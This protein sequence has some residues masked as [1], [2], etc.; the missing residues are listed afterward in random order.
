M[1]DPL[2]IHVVE[3]ARERAAFVDLP[4]RI[5]AGLPC[6]VP[7]LRRMLRH[8]LDFRANPF[9]QHAEGCLFIARRGTAVLGRICA[10]IDHAYIAQWHEPVGSFG[11]F[12][13]VD[14]V[15]VARALV[16]AAAA[17][18][19]QR[20]MGVLRGPMSPS[21]HGEWGLL[22]EGFA[23]PPALLMPYN[24][25]YYRALLE[26]CG[27]RPAKTVLAYEKTQD[28]QSPAALARIAARL[29][30]NPRVR[31]ERMRKA[32]LQ[33][34][35]ETVRALYN[36]TWSEQWGFAPLSTAEMHE[37]LDA[38]R[39]FGREELALLA[40]YDDQPVG[41]CITLPDIN[42]ILRDA[43]G[44]LGVRTLWRLLF[45]QRRITGCRT[46]LLGFLP[47]F[48]R[49]GL[50]ALLYHASETY[51]RAHFQRIEFSWILEDNLPMQTLISAIGATVSKR[52]QLFELQLP[53]SP[54]P[55]SCDEHC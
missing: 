30:R 28:S 55:P 38:V 14:E 45:Q 2:H 12:E 5:Y 7:P 6:W 37:F 49:T 31:I 11:F 32:A 10:Q 16:H 47:Q 48:R 24:P 46:M 15:V 42:E 23:R 53:A 9:W 27:L 19:Q 40:Y 50:P 34:K 36:V 35:A 17:W 21:C 26:A 8:Q 51:V 18:L 33:R 44:R 25:P 1:A 3:S 54:S 43:N 41:L 52:Y 22:I 13:C 20:G 29:L 39:F 4:W